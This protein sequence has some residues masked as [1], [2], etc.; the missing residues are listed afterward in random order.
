MSTQLFD[1]SIL[2][3]KELYS[4]YQDENEPYKF[5]KPDNALEPILNRYFH[6]AI[7]QRFI[8]NFMN[9]DSHVRSLHL[10]HST[11]SGKTLGSLYLANEYVMAYQKIYKNNRIG[12]NV[13]RKNTIDLSPTVFILGFSASQKVFKKELMRYS[14]FGIISEEEIV[15]LQIKESQSKSGVQSDIKVYKEHKDRVKRRI[16]N[17]EKGG[18]YQFLGYEEL[19]NRLFYS[20]VHKL[21]ELEKEAEKND[22]ELETIY[23]KYLADGSIQIN[24]EFLALFKDSF[25]LCDEIHVT[26]NNAK[27]ND[28]GIALQY[29]LSR[30]KPYLLTLSA[31]PIKGAP[32]ECV[33]WINYHRCVNGLPLI[34]KEE[35]YLNDKKMKYGMLE[36]F[37][38][39]TRG[40]V[41]FFQDINYDDYPE[42]I[43][44]G[45]DLILSE[46]TEWMPKGTV[47]PYLKFTECQMSPFHEATYNRYMTDEDTTKINVGARALLDIA[48]P[49][50]ESNEIGIFKSSE[51]APK[52]LSADIS[53]RLEKGIDIKKTHHSIS[54]A[55]GTWLQVDNLVKYSTKYTKLITNI[56]DI[57][58]GHGEANK[59]QKTII[60]HHKV[61]G[62]GVLLLQEI[63]L[64][65]GF[66]DEFANPTDHTICWVCGTR[67]MDHPQTHEYFPARIVMAH[68]DIDKKTLD[69]SL[70]KFN[71][72][73]NKNGLY[74]SVLIGSKMISESYDFKDIQQLHIL[75]VPVN[76]SSL[77]Q[78]FGRAIRKNASIALPPSQ[79]RTEIRIYVSTSNNMS[80]SYEVRAYADKLSSYL[81]IQEIEREII[82]NAVDIK[83]HWNTIM[84]QVSPDNPSL[85]ALWFPKPEMPS[86]NNITPIKTTIFNKVGYAD[87]E[88]IDI[89]H[90]IKRMFLEE[91]V[92]TYDRLFAA[93]K[94]PRIPLSLNPLLFEEGNF[95]IALSFMLNGSIIIHNRLNNGATSKLDRFV[96][97]IYNPALRTIYKEGSEHKIKQVGDYFILF[98][99]NIFIKDNWSTFVNYTYNTMDDVE[100]YLRPITGKRHQEVNISEYLLKQEYNEEYLSMKDKLIALIRMKKTD[101]YITELL[102]D[103]S[104]RFQIKILEEAIETENNKLADKNEKLHKVIELYTTMGAIIMSNEIMLYQDVF[105]YYEGKTLKK[106]IPLGY[107]IR[108]NIR[109]FHN[110]TKK[111]FEISKVSLNR[112]IKYRDNNIIIGYLQDEADIIK[113]KLM[114]TQSQKNKDRRL[115][116]RG[117]V[118][119]F[120]D[121]Y[122]VMDIA[123]SLGISLKKF[124]QRELKINN[125]CGIIRDFLL[126][127]EMKDRLRGSQYKWVYGWWD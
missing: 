104:E 4:L 73:S 7:Q 61:R 24:E 126:N 88:V 52:I 102:Y 59:C 23:E 80:N 92:W 124:N 43:F 72:P 93:I 47:L 60:Y 44:V 95:V 103:Y 49:N 6:P 108:N 100:T 3:N 117:M 123:A 39:L 125:I 53:W 91:P 1:E 121:K 98:P 27:K 54:I 87:N 31:T 58:R 65:N 29:I 113:F 37:G 57:I 16:T 114:P 38:E 69:S 112:H 10:F 122:E 62:S 33:D 22:V 17:K 35:F 45:E 76:I 41:S 34:T 46:D 96:E 68:S 84:K 107:C 28:R 78:T 14:I 120:R 110:D 94:E 25:V 75:S 36:K 13:F 51:I 19:V 48:F 90:I 2:L 79:R 63:L 127:R 83:I 118:C 11:G 70:D 66:I 50:P 21:N 64:H 71:H 106:N 32:K 20:E 30:V 97:S 9:V 99:V 5:A 40:L 26:Y 42:R 109:L 18:F 101:E 56:L 116:V 85:G 119:S 12:K 105:K 8:H 55:T 77:I 86:S 67:L 82:K 111:W 15:E 81:Y 115:D 74:Y 89:I